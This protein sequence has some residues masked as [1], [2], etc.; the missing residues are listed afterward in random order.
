MKKILVCG[1]LTITMFVALNANA[2]S[3]RCNYDV[4]NQVSGGRITGEILYHNTCD[5]PI[6][7]AVA[8]NVYN[9]K[10]EFQYTTAGISVLSYAEAGRPKPISLS[11]RG[12][13][14]KLELV[15]WLNCK[16]GDCER[17]IRRYKK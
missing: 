4:Y 3:S 11:Y 15:D 2:Q 1:F 12:N 13:G 7:I 5:E 10:W 9:S 14:D 8:Y 17:F 16:E 6:K